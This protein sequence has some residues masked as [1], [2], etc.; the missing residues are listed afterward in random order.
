MKRLLVAL[1]GLALSLGALGQELPL[2]PLEADSLYLMDFFWDKLQARAEKLSDASDTRNAYPWDAK[3]MSQS[4]VERL[5]AQW[6]ETVKD[7]DSTGERRDGTTTLSQSLALF[8]KSWQL[9]LHTAQ[10]RYFDMAE[11]ILANSIIKRWETDPDSAARQEAARL[12][13][14]LDRM[15]YATSGKD[16]YVN[17]LTSCNAHLKTGDMDIYL[18]CVGQHPW[19]NKTGISFVSDL[20][21]FR[22]EDQNTIDE[23]KSVIYHDEVSTDS[24]ELTFHIRVPSWADGQG[25]GEGREVKSNKM[26]KIQVVVIGVQLSH[27][28][29]R[30]GYIV[31]SG[32]W[33]LRDIIGINL[34]TRLLRV[35]D[36]QHPGEVAL[37]RGPFVYGVIAPP[38]QARLDPGAAIHQSYSKADDAVVLNGLMD[39]DGEDARFYAVPYYIDNERTKVFVQSK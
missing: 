9:G 28:E 31:I 10:A 39:D 16:V 35:S 12:L 15:I 21:P 8:G 4:K 18:Q 11:R 22:I 37:Q 19:Y 33:T 23:F 24:V 27:P 30:D 5:A 29:I 26:P 14:T 7:L 17:L 6:E 13:Q 38:G 2:M 25:F 20:D 1:W 36:T 34:P 32:K 3:K